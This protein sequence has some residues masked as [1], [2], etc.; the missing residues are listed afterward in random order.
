[1]QK[2]IALMVI[3]MQYGF[4]DVA[5]AEFQITLSSHILS[6]LTAVRSLGLPVVHVITEYE[7]DKSNWPRAWIHRDQLRCVRDTPG[8]RVLEELRP[9]PT[10]QLIRKTRFT[11]FYETQLDSWLERNAI[12]EIVLCGYA[13]DVCVRMT[14]MDAFNRGYATTILSDCVL[15]ERATLKASLEYLEWLTDARV[16]MSRDWLDG[17]VAQGQGTAEPGPP[18][19]S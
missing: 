12:Y 1:M 2:S 14:A 3:D 7:P 15:P 11:A 6:C 13:A 5:P 19:R 18:K 8:A 16:M 9:M 10:E 4:I 17:L